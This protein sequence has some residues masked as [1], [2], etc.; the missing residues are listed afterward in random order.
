MFFLDLIV[1][2]VRKKAQNGNRGS[3]KPYSIFSRSRVTGLIGVILIVF[4]RM[5][6]LRD[7]IR[8]QPVLP[9]EKPALLFP[10]S[11]QIAV[12]MG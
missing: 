9:G 3:I 12:K 1:P 11:W 4:S 5:P 6:D 10:F 2:H 8:K 7:W